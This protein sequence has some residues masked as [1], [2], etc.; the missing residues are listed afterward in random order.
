LYIYPRYRNIGYL[1]E[2]KDS[3]TTSNFI[4]EI[5][6]SNVNSPSLINKEHYLLDLDNDYTYF[7]NVFDEVTNKNIIFTIDLKE[8]DSSHNYYISGIDQTNTIFD[9]NITN[10]LYEK[11]I[12]IET[13]NIIEFNINASSSHPFVI[14]KSDTNP[15]RIMNDTNRLQGDEITYEGNYYVNKG[16]ING[17]ILWNTDNS[18]IGTYYGICVNHT[19]MYFKINLID[20]QNPFIKYDHNTNILQVL[21]GEISTNNYEYN[22]LVNN[23]YGTSYNTLSLVKNTLTSN[24]IQSISDSL[25]IESGETKVINLFNYKFAN[26]YELINEITNIN[27][28]LVNNI[29][30]ITNSSNGIYDLLINMDDMLYI[31]RI[32]EN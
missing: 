2:L 15:Q 27:I 12:T 18:E 24:T 28:N 14:V 8:I 5:V 9:D 1:V 4:I 26:T 25:I 21:N 19:G 30:T 17:K 23:Y 22:I 7:S 16:L 11:T 29:L 20:D 32:T 6:E 10:D 13:S 3:I 31:F